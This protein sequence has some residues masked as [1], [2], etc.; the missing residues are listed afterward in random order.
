MFRDVIIARRRINDDY[1]HYYPRVFALL[2]LFVL[3]LA[4]SEQTEAAV[5]AEIQQSEP[6]AITT[7]AVPVRVMEV[8]SDG[9]EQLLRFAGVARPRQRATLS[10]QVGGS[11]ETRVAQI[12]HLVEEN[13]I[14]ARLYNPQ[15]EPAMAAAAA[16]LEQLRSDAEQAERDLARLEQLFER[17]LL[18]S[19]DVEQQRTAL[20][21]VRAAIDN[22]RANLAQTRQLS[23]ESELR[24]P[25]SG[26]I[27][28]VLLEPGEFAQP[29]QP[30]LRMSAVDGLE[31]EV[32][33]PPR[34]LRDIALGDSLTVWNGLSDE[35]FAGLITEIGEGSSGGT[36]LY[37]LV[38]SLQETGLRSGEALEVGVPRR[39]ESALHIPLNAVMRS[40]QG[41]TVFKVTDDDRAERIAV[42]VKRITG[43]QVQLEPGSLQAGDRV[44][45]AGLTRLADGDRVTVLTNSENIRENNRG[46][47]SGDNGDSGRESGQ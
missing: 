40:A 22:A 33:V 47:N 1:R 27:E 3:P 12:G 11:I 15:L 28:Q 26:R 19:Q 30:V 32:Q 46:N 31:V 9:G 29:G 18:A 43:D 25:F 37:P 5:E 13:E 21:S 23:E 7:V 20:K 44:V 41:L 17:G 38:V 8:Q 14:V 42:N 24:A 36:A 35:M 4:C 10:F 45:Y 39:E 6:A 34:F 16:R 2:L